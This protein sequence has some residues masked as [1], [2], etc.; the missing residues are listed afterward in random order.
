MFGKKKKITE[1][2]QKPQKVHKNDAGKVIY[3]QSTDKVGDVLV[4]QG[5]V[6]MKIT[7]ERFAPP[8]GYD[9]GKLKTRILTLTPDKKSGVP[10][11]ELNDTM[12]E[13]YRKNGVLTRQ[14]KAAPK[15]KKTTSPRGKARK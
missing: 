1:K 9:D 14:K 12:V 10:E 6:R 15:P 8:C 13:H 7:S 5:G 4:N 2:T 3:K 11:F